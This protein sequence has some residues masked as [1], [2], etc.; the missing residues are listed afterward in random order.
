MVCTFLL[1][2]SSP[3]LPFS[4]VIPSIYEI[5]IVKTK[6]AIPTPDSGTLDHYGTYVR[7]LLL[8]RDTTSQDLFHYLSACPNLINLAIWTH[9]A[10]PDHLPFMTKMPLQRLSANV[11]KIFGSVQEFSDAC[12][13]GHPALVRLTHLDIINAHGTWEDWAGLAHLRDLMH[14][15]VYAFISDDRFLDGVLEHCTQ[16]HVMKLSEDGARP[17]PEVEVHRRGEYQFAVGKVL[18]YV[19]DWRAGARGEREVWDYAE[20]VLGGACI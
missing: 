13:G 7:H 6:S 16:V 14:L 17:T 18:N 1:P 19:E 11:E 3:C 8:G 4:R 15:S 12:R 2:P 9:E 5:I 20:Q 10:G